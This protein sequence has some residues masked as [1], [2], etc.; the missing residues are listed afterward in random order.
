MKT[1]AVGAYETTSQQTTPRVLGGTMAK[2]ERGCHLFDNAVSQAKSK[3]APGKYDGMKQ[4][5]RIT[6]PT[7][8]TPRSLSRNPKGPH[9]VGPGYYNINMDP[10]ER[11][12][13]SYSA[14]K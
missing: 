2:R 7:F 10:V 4:E 6:S 11:R 8:S 3:P 1:P 13:P 12:Q 14:S 5:T 9:Q